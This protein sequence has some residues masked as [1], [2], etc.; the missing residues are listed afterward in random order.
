M[1]I[2]STTSRHGLVCGSI[3]LVLIV[4]ALTT[5]LGSQEL[6]SQRRKTAPEVFNA[7][8]RVDATSSV[9]DV[10]V[11][12]EVDR[13]TPE[14]SLQAMEQALQAGGS[15]GFLDALRAAPIVG[16][17][18]IGRQTFAIRWAREHLTSTGRV[19]SFVTDSPVYF[20]GGGVPGAKPRDGFDVAILQ[21]TMDSS[22]IGNGTMAAA[23]RVKPG[24]ATGLEIEDY[25]SAPVKLISV[26]RLMS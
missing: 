20:V 24:G 19:I 12:I 14:R 13:Y 11:T 18:R 2:I 1:K 22:G 3:T 5:V 17:V 15:T 6:R 25:A 26:M 16:H 8:A 23:A 21:L 7:K 9:G 4:S 10:L